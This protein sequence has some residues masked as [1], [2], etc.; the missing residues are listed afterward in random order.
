MGLGL[1]REHRV[2]ARLRLIGVFG[3]AVLG[4]GRRYD[5]ARG[6]THA[7]SRLCGS[8]PLTRRRGALPVACRRPACRS[9]QKAGCVQQRW[10]SAAS[11]TPA[12]KPALRPARTGSSTRCSTP[13][14]SGVRITRP[15]ACTTFCS[16]GIRQA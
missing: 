12:A 16:P 7:G 11:T 14:S 5:V 1:P 9:V 13:V 6:G 4:R 8:A 10:P 15:A 2:R 3:Q